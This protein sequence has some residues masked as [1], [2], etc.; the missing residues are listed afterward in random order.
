MRGLLYRYQGGLLIS[1]NTVTRLSWN[2][3]SMAFGLS[4]ALLVIGCGGPEYRPSASTE[5]N[6]SVAQ[7]PKKP[8]KQIVIAQPGADQKNVG[9][10]NSAIVAVDPTTQAILN[11]CIAAAK[12][13]GNGPTAVQPNSPASVARVESAPAATAGTATI[14][15]NGKTYV[16][17]RNV[18][19]QQSSGP[20]VV[21][22]PQ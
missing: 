22:M 7:A 16:L 8:D 18:Q 14:T 9:Q 21:G 4:S 3:A 2:L 6:Q 19:A 17:P 13:A 12:A 5:A 11:A 20:Q 10:N 1:Q 15:C